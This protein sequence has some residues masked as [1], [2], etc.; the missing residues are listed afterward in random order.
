ME[1]R[2]QERT[3]AREL[4]LTHGALVKGSS[5]PARRW[6]DATTRLG[7]LVWLCAVAAA[8]AVEGEGELGVVE[9]V[10]AVTLAST[11]LERADDSRPRFRAA[12]GRAHTT[13]AYLWGL[14]AE[15]LVSMAD[16]GEDGGD[17]KAAL[18]A[19]R[20]A[21][22]LVRLS[23]WRRPELLFKYLYQHTGDARVLSLAQRWALALLGLGGESL[24]E[25]RC[26]SE[27][28]RVHL[29]RLAEVDPTAVER[30]VVGDRAAN[31]GGGDALPG[32]CDAESLFMMGE[33]LRSCM[34]IDT[35][36][37]RENRALLEQLAQPHRLLLLRDERGRVAAR[38]TARLLARSDS[39]APVVFVDQPL[40]KGGTAEEALEAEVL[41]MA[42]ALGE[43]LGGVPVVLWRECVDPTADEAPNYE[44]PAVAPGGEGVELIEYDGVAPFL[45]TNLQG[46]VEREGE[47]E[48]YSRRGKA[49]GRTRG[50]GRAVVHAVLRRT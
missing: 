22:A 50:E 6:A 38:A 19:G 20:V 30:W 47:S 37:V 18:P 39:G 31:G 17:A 45:Y 16:D 10:R 9:A 7:H 29:G 49:G 24:H 42:Q 43:A 1:Q 12:L 26:A 5:R 40:Y 32:T 35:Q 21:A 15:Q 48:R 11:A 14:L 33:E 36:C 34:R 2:A 3:T 25:L 44:K 23:G 27:A 46:L 28:N 41:A 8:D 13:P 4:A